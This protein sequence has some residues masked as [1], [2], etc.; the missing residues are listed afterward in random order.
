MMEE[1]PD[2]EEWKTQMR[3]QKH[4]RYIHGTFG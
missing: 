1:Q 2:E 3:N 4:E